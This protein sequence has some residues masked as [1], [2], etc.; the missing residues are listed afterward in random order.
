MVFLALIMCVSIIGGVFVANSFMTALNPALTE[1]GEVIEADMPLGDD[2]NIL[3][4]GT[5]GSS[6]L[7]DTM[8]LFHIDTKTRTLKT[9]SIPRDTR[10]KYNNSHI[11]INSAY[12][13]KGREK[14]TIEAVK[15]LTGLPVNYYVTVGL[16]GFRGIIDYLGGVDINVPKDMYYSDPAQKLNINLKAGMQHMD[17]ATAEK[18]VRFRKG[19]VDQD[20]GRMHAQQEFIKELIRQKFTLANIV[21]AKS[22]FEELKKYV[23]TNYTLGEIVSTANK[24]KGMDTTNILS[25]DVPGEARTIDNISYWVADDAE[26]KLLIESN[27]SSK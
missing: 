18:Y 3:V 12:G 16:N 27:F 8:I 19:Y 25:F 5:D 9:L 2:M 14:S 7:T 4:L 20:I 17:G 24:L 13:Y 21:R 1:D 10:V 11:K 6:L 23:S 15:T 26:L 22:I